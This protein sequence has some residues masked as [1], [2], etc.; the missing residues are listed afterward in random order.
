MFKFPGGWVEKGETIKAGVEREVL[1]ETAWDDV[2][3]GKLPAK[4]VREARREEVTYM[5]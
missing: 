1:E 2:R 5:H 3:G 4:L